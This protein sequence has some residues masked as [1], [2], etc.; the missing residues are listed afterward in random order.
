M[1]YSEV[2][3]TAEFAILILHNW[4]PFRVQPKVGR[5]RYQSKPSPKLAT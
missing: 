4:I 5:H 1:E 2:K 3:L